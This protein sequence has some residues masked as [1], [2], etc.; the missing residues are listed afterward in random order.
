MRKI[1]PSLMFLLPFYVSAQE[2][3]LDS[4]KAMKPA[5]GLFYAL[6]YYGVYEPHIVYAQAVLETGH[7][8][9]SLC[10]KYGNLF[11]IYDSRAKQYVHYDHWIESVVA[12]RDKVQ[13]KWKGGDYI[14][15]LRN[16]PYA[17]DP[18]YCDKVA[19]IAENYVQYD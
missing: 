15:F 18:D 10:V 5:D 14:E 3:T 13:A 11:G 8:K 2:V 7:F 6:E 1:V 19:K 17:Q 9:S 4:I 12:Y 16:L